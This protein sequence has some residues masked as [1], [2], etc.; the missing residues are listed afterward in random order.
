MQIVRGAHFLSWSPSLH[1]K[2]NSYSCLMFS[3]IL[4]W[5]FVIVNSPQM[6]QKESAEF[7]QPR[8]DMQANFKSY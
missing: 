6:Q 3:V 4:R 5:Y 2:Y 1:P 8:A 7:V